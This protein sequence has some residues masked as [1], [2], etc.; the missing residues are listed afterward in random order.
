MENGEAPWN[1]DDYNFDR[2]RLTVQKKERIEDPDYE[3]PQ[4]HMHTAPQARSE[5][6]GAPVSVTGLQ[7]VSSKPDICCLVK[8]C[9][10]DLANSKAYYRRFRICEAHMK[11][12]SLSIEG[13]SCRFC[14]Q[15]GKF[16]LVEEFDGSNRN[17]R[18]ALM[19]RFYKR[20]NMPL[21][22]L[23]SASG[24]SDTQAAATSTNAYSQQE[25]KLEPRKRGR[26]RAPRPDILEEEQAATSGGSGP[27]SPPPV[28]GSNGA[29][30]ARAAAAA[31]FDSAL[32]AAYMA[33]SR[34]Y[35]GTT[36]L[37]VT[38]AT[39]IGPPGYSQGGVRMAGIEIDEVDDEH[40][41]RPPSLR[42]R[43]TTAPHVLTAAVGGHGVDKQGRHGVGGSDRVASGIT[44]CGEIMMDGIRTHPTLQ[45]Q[46]QM[47]TLHV[48]PGHGTG[49]PA[50]RVGQGSLGYVPDGKRAGGGSGG[51]GGSGSLSRCSSSHSQDLDGVVPARGVGVDGRCR[52]ALPQLGTGAPVTKT[53]GGSSDGGCEPMDGLDAR[54]GARGPILD[55][56]MLSGSAAQLGLA[57]LLGGLGGGGL[58]QVLPAQPGREGPRLQLLRGPPAGQ[59][60]EESAWRG[61]TADAGAVPPLSSRPSHTSTRSSDDAAAAAAAA[62]RTLKL[63]GISASGGG[64][65]QSPQRYRLPSD[66]QEALPGDE[67]QLQQ[68]LRVGLQHQWG[69]TG[70]GKAALAGLSSMASTKREGVEVMREPGSSATAAAVAA[71]VTAASAQGHETDRGVRLSLREAAGGG[72]GGGGGGGSGLD[73]FTSAQ[74]LVS[75][76]RWCPSDA[77]M[78]LPLGLRLGTA[79]GADGGVSGR[80]Y[81]RDR[82]YEFECE[83]ERGR[84][85]LGLDVGSMMGGTQSALLLGQHGGL[86]AADD[87][88]RRTGTASVLSLDVGELINATRGRTADAGGGGG[89]DAARCGAGGNVQYLRLE[90]SETATLEPLRAEIRGLGATAGPPP[91]PSAATDE[92]KRNAAVARLLS[93]M[94]VSQQLELL[95]QMPYE[96]MIAL[97]QMLPHPQQVGL[98]LEL[99]NEHR[100][101]VI[102]QQQQ[103]QQLQQLQ[104]H[105]VLLQ[106]RG[107]T[108]SGAGGG[109]TL[110]LDLTVDPPTSPAASAA[111]VALGPVVPLAR[112]PS[113]QQPLTPLGLPQQQQQYSELLPQQ[114]HE[115]A[116]A[117]GP[118]QFLSFPNAS[119]RLQRMPDGNMVLELPVTAATPGE[120]AGSAAAAMPVLRLQP[121]S[122]PGTT[123]QLT[124][125][126][127][128]NGGAPA[129]AL[130]GNSSLLLNLTNGAIR[131][132][133]NTLVMRGGSAGA[134]G[135]KA[136]AGISGPLLAVDYRS[137]D[138]GRDS[139]GGEDALERLSLKLHGMRPEQLAPDV[140]QRLQAWLQSMDAVTLQGTLRSGCVNLVLDVNLRLPAQRGRHTRNPT[141]V[142]GGFGGSDNDGSKTRGGRVAMTCTDPSP[143]DA[144]VGSAYACC[145]GGDA[146]AKEGVPDHVADRLAAAALAAALGLDMWLDSGDDA[147]ATAAA[148]GAAAATMGVRAL[149]QVGSQ[150]VYPPLE[151]RSTSAVA[152]VVH[153]LAPLAIVQGAPAVLY[154][155]GKFLA[156]NAVR[157]HVRLNGRRLG[158][159]VQMEAELNDDGMDTG[160]HP[161]Q[162][163]QT[164]QQQRRW[165]LA[166]HMHGRTGDQEAQGSPSAGLSD[167]QALLSSHEDSGCS[168][169]DIVGVTSLH[170]TGDTTIETVEAGTQDQ[171]SGAGAG[172]GEEM[173]EGMGS[174]AEG[175]V[176]ELGSDAGAG[177]GQGQTCS[178]KGSAVGE[179]M[180]YLD[181]PTGPG[182]AVLEWETGIGG[183]LGGWWP[184]VV[185]PNAEVAAEVNG[186][187]AWQRQWR[188]QRPPCRA[189]PGSQAWCGEI[190][191]PADGWE[192][193]EEEEDAEAREDYEDV[194]R[195][196][197]LL[198]DLG[199]VLDALYSSNS[200]GNSCCC[201]GKDNNSS[202]ASS[203]GYGTSA[204]NIDWEA[205]MQDLLRR[206][207]LQSPKCPSTTATAEASAHSKCRSAVAWEWSDGGNAHKPPPHSSSAR[208]A[209]GYAPDARM[210]SIPIRGLVPCE[211]WPGGVIS[212][213][214]GAPTT[215]GTSSDLP[216]A[217]T[218]SPAEAAAASKVAAAAH[219]GM[220]PDLLECFVRRAKRLL[221]YCLARAMPHTAAEV[222]LFLT[223]VA[224]V[225][226][227]ELADMRIHTQ[228]QL[229]LYE[230][231]DL[232]Q[233]LDRQ[234]EAAEPELGGPLSSSVDAPDGGFSLLHLAA[235]S[236]C[237]RCVDVL[238][239]EGLWNDVLLDPLAAGPG[240]WTPV[241]LAAVHASNS[242]GTCTPADILSS[243]LSYIAAAW[244]MAMAAAALTS[245]PT[246]HLLELYR[247]SE[248]SVPDLRRL[249]V[250]A[251]ACPEVRAPLLDSGNAVEVS[252]DGSAMPS[253]S[254]ALI[255]CEEVTPKLYGQGH[256]TKPSD[257]I[258][259]KNA[260]YDSSWQ[261]E[262][263]AVTVAAAIGGGGGSDSNGGLLLLGG[264]GLPKDGCTDETSDS[265][266]NISGP[267]SCGMSTASTSYN[268]RGVNTQSQFQCL[269]SDDMSLSFSGSFTTS[270]DSD[271]GSSGGCGCGENSA[272]SEESD[273]D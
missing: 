177:Q 193:E 69:L 148:V 216:P 138:G 200:S 183:V 80:S 252:S 101:R 207:R 37:G 75:E 19:I 239:K 202:N 150:V 129:L 238:L 187:V 236:G 160:Q 40:D 82:S 159:F 262:D 78:D 195:L 233:Q 272:D 93:Q 43:S 92:E 53:A 25:L 256:G 250:V 84:E 22:S 232:G 196:H 11:S 224:R 205:D 108:G 32:Q 219:L 141:E 56:G 115:S 209:S 9:H 13:R 130:A 146:S 97:L 152:P 94:P 64:G 103:Q 178:S 265:D 111:R 38:P 253:S 206:L 179:A 258:S 1:E 213:A 145:G 190:P 255:T 104:Q 188:P 134:Q 136:M 112:K 172:T 21:T 95:Q 63:G 175:E 62:R 137:R 270:G 242:T 45:L 249:A 12:L 176:S 60:L 157:L 198:T 185:A 180:V 76:P 68:Q 226:F 67:Q 220:G 15:C 49:A 144:A 34:G 42:R 46:N 110:A 257:S 20:R 48:L 201:N 170:G 161:S 164:Q 234:T 155:V 241:Q 199:L 54:G 23:Q 151:R 47:A 72:G 147:P 99:Q 120:S 73:I 259:P 184:L 96:Q 28:G 123:M 81:N 35:Q 229:Q 106:A 230:Q 91:P 158:A 167:R 154:M 29:A 208:R 107:G 231:Q 14:Q 210:D 33:A 105:L 71:A 66:Y 132:P 7:S 116:G 100:V 65:R 83:R 16:H 119:T 114:Q 126:D 88:H 4:V 217:G 18:K 240:G 124:A 243:L 52:A 24:R 228:L 87:A 128:G 235:S 266:G 227:S 194:P 221:P 44:G 268:Q 50:D 168:V 174:Q 113:R 131:L 171:A 251:C 263:A 109:A 139:G 244:H 135:S 247:S 169:T 8:G 89:G 3:Q 98:L 225:P 86:A 166:C 191:G 246:Q 273:V 121:M 218:F 271:S 41:R 264:G 203:S 214:T 260:V 133:S 57:S 165:Q 5:P 39:A 27:G 212:C 223:R 156:G 140:S 90:P 122:G 173:D 31:G 267:C 74:R 261:L 197:E 149:V 245:T 10:A 163:T 237:V 102:Q 248:G 30:A 211:T 51:S 204:G 61:A 58:L 269:Y 36:G 118:L 162:Q 254:T 85:I 222:L 17:C 26:P 215:A 142:A 117:V 189:D 153:E 143:A 186:M 6:Q 70:H 182:L 127:A 55:A 181:P 2:R 125:G 79:A 77:A 59:P 192:Q